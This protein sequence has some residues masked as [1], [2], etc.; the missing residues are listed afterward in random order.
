MWNY[1]PVLDFENVTVKNS[2]QIPARIW[3]CIEIMSSSFGD[4]R[5]AGMDG[6]TDSLLSLQSLHCRNG[7]NEYTCTQFVCVYWCLIDVSV[8]KI[9]WHLCIQDGFLFRLINFS[10]R[11]TR[12][13]LTYVEHSGCTYAYIS[14]LS[15][16]VFHYPF[17]KKWICVR[18]FN[19]LTR[20]RE[21]IAAC[22]NIQDI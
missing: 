9:G 14:L 22:C 4:K 5:H 7:Q 13:V 19:R 15:N 10:T 17:S 12:P 1:D 6:D 11:S 2:W 21:T 20:Y 18:K 8:I 3:N 16:N